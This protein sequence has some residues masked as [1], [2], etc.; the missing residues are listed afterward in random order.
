MDAGA[1]LGAAASWPHLYSS[2]PATFLSPPLVAIVALPFL[3]IPL[4]IEPLIWRLALAL[5]LVVAWKL[6][7][8]KR[9]PRLWLL[10]LLGNPITFFTLTQGQITPFV[11]LGLALAVWLWR[12]GRLLEAGLALALAAQMKP[13][14]FIALPLALLAANQ[15]RLLLGLVLGTFALALLYTLLLSPAWLIDFLSATISDHH[16]LINA[17]SN[18]VASFGALAWVIRIL[19]LLL[20]PLVAYRSRPEVALIGALIAS[21]VLTP[22]LHQEDLLVVFIIAWL[23]AAIHSPSLSVVVCAAG[24]VAAALFS[25]LLLLTWEFVTLLLVSKIARPFSLVP[26]SRRLL[27]ARIPFSP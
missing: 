8:L 18:T 12:R 4:N 1:F 2:Q 7:E 16:N 17:Q 26:L 15:A 23:F 22:Y 6:I 14:L 5:A 9:S 24:L 27:I 13:T 10:V 20:V 19:I 21:L 25:P 11:L 3:H